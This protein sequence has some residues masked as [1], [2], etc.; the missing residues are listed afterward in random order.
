MTVPGPGVVGKVWRL[1]LQPAGLIQ[2]F[3]EAL[4]HPLLKGSAY[5]PRGARGPTEDLRGE[6]THPTG[7]ASGLQ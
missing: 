7:P 6:G 4:P 5:L 2:W 1:C 3:R